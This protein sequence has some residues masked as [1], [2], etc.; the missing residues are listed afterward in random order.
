VKWGDR[1]NFLGYGLGIRLPVKAGTL[2][3]EWA[4]NKDDIKSWGRV[5]VQVGN[6]NTLE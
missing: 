2:T 6:N 1:I 3:L 5:N 4:R